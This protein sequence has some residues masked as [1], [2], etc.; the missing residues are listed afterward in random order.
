MY[1][2]SSTAIM[3]EL[4]AKISHLKT[5]FYALRSL[6]CWTNSVYWLCNHSSDGHFHQ[7]CSQRTWCHSL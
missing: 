4:T 1:I 2:P 6:C 3:P 7:N 5:I